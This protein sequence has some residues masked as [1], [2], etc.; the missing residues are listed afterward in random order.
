MSTLSCLLCVDDGGALALGQDLRSG[1]EGLNHAV[2]ARA[3]DKR[4][5]PGIQVGLRGVHLGFGEEPRLVPHLKPTLH[6]PPPPSHKASALAR[7]TGRC[8]TG[9]G[10][11]CASLAATACAG[12][13]GSSPSQGY[14]VVD[15]VLPVVGID[16][17]RFDAP[18]RHVVPEGKKG[19]GHNIGLQSTNQPQHSHGTVTAQP[20]HSHS[21]ATC[22]DGNWSQHRIA[23]HQSATAQSQHS[24][25]TA[26]CTDGNWSQHRIAKQQSAPDR[27]GPE[28]ECATRRV[29]D[30]IWR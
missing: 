21:T 27:H 5:E 1:R 10:R 7:P 22:T 2:A 23:K 30:R 28:V 3:L 18:A 20:Q 14:L 17:H 6:S 12:V 24:H 25:S 4:R 19:I 15:P 8:R 9:P 16:L 11:A 26:I 29:R 13:V